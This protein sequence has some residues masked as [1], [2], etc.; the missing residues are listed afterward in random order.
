MDSQT[1]DPRPLLE[2]EE[3]R[4]RQTGQRELE[5][6]PTSEAWAV[7]EDV[8][9]APALQERLKEGF[10][11]SRVLEA[12]PNFIENVMKVPDQILLTHSC[13]VLGPAAAGKTTL[14]KAVCPHYQPRIEPGPHMENRTLEAQAVVLQIENLLNLEGLQM[15]VI[16]TPGWSQNTSTNILSEYKRILRERQLVSEHTPHIILL[17]IPVS[18]IRQ[19][20]DA[21]AERMSKQLYELN[22]D[23]RFPIKVLPVATKADSERVQDRDKLLSAIK[24]LAEK[25]FQGTGAD[26]ED[27]IYMM[28]PPEGCPRGVEELNS[29]LRAILSAQIQSREFKG[30]LHKAFAK[31]LAENIRKHCEQ[32]PENDSPIRL[33]QRCYRLVEAICGHE[34][35]NLAMPRS[36]DALDLPWRKI[37]EVAEKEKHTCTLALPKF[38][39]LWFYYRATYFGSCWRAA[40]FVI[41]L[42][43]PISTL[44]FYAGRCE[45]WLALAIWYLTFLVLPLA[46]LLCKR[47]RY[48]IG[49]QHL[50][51][52][53]TQCRCL[54]LCLLLV[55][56][57]SSCRLHVMEE[58][59]FTNTRRT[60]ALKEKL[61]AMTQKSEEEQQLA[62]DNDEKA[63]EYDKLMSCV[64]QDQTPQCLGLF[65][66]G[67]VNDAD[68]C[69]DVCCKMGQDQCSTWQYA[70]NLGCWV[71][72]PN[73]C[74]GHDG[75][76]TGGQRI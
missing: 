24:Q 61:D 42:S 58:E 30:L 66:L 13:L 74:D 54:A 6:T 36:Q 67:T 26:V 51:S 70:E 23:K 48:W 45:M 11:D 20:Q 46:P 52:I 18:F 47:I 41:L 71:G 76:W 3:A 64:W 43:L 17:C 1:V 50:R 60:I 44:P 8:E 39:T 9:V 72:N 34:A 27:P 33:Y 7:L 75:Q 55:V 21:E 38:Q 57:L 40:S 29:R 62:N 28:F 12:Q 25:A 59:L 65:N 10:Q 5:E 2:G 63:K 4:H 22:F 73:S 31:C 35:S 68:A 16:D 32:F 56:L 14:I 49:S 69:E 37:M 53:R 15:V 19:F